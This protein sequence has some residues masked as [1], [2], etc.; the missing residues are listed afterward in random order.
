VKIV[1]R[2]L[3]E[4]KLVAFIY[5]LRVRRLTRVRSLETGKHSVLVHVLNFLFFSYQQI[6]TGRREMASK[7]LNYFLHLVTLTS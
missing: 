3:R 7:P 1:K 4:G 5:L 6:T 2:S